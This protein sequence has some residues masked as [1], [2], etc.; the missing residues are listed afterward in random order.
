M[1]LLKR[2]SD[3]LTYVFR[4]RESDEWVRTDMEILIK[5]GPDSKW[6][7]YSGDA[8]V[9]KPM[10]NSDSSSLPPEGEWISSKNGKSYI[11]DV[12]FQSDFSDLGDQYERQENL[13]DWNSVLDEVQAVTQLKDA[14]SLD[15]GC[16]AGTVAG[17]MAAR[18]AKV[19]GIDRDP[20]MVA[21][22]HERCPNGRFLVG[23]ALEPNIRRLESVG[24]TEFDIIWTSFVISYFPDPVAFIENWS[25]ALRQGGL[26]CLLDVSGLFSVHRPMDDETLDVCNRLDSA[27][28]PVYFSSYGSRLGAFCIEAGL[29]VVRECPIDDAEFAFTGSAT[30]ECLTA[31]AARLRRP[32]ISKKLSEV[33]DQP[34]EFVQKFL[35]C[36]SLKEH[37]VMA[38]PV[39]VIARR[40]LI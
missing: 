8:I 40:K 23:D 6:G 30:P 15:V 32:F 18:G 37:S 3:G 7:C 27:L 1:L 11:Y 14:L 22:S 35:E 33:T 17:L 24:A 29:E 34:E 38:K 28:E 16:G 5:K 25:S 4:R 10:I 26:L 39:L 21:L 20:V 36:L 13:R 31:W 2:K 9:G 19:V 12:S